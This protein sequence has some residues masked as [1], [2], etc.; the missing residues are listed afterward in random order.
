MPKKPTS[1]ARVP[2]NGP[3]KT[4]SVKNYYDNGVLMYK[5]RLRD[6][7]MHGKWEWFRRDATKMRTGEFDSGKQSG[8][9]RTFDR[10][11]R[12]VKETDFSK[13]K[14]PAPAKLKKRKGAPAR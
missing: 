8:I 12:L 1:S 5:G 2:K 6:G 4:K 9:W 11:G 10:D 7:K 13:K 14:K 3:A